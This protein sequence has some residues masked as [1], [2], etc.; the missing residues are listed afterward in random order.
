MKSLSTQTLYSVHVVMYEKW[1][2]QKIREP[3]KQ[4]EVNN[5]PGIE[6]RTGGLG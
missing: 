1:S 2:G 3:I 5:D 4:G 6:V